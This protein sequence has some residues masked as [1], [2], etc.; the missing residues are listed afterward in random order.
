MTVQP[1]HVALYE[2]QSFL[3]AS[4]EHHFISHSLMTF[5]W[6]PYLDDFIRHIREV[7]C[8]LVIVDCVS[9]D[10]VLLQRLAPDFSMNTVL[11][12]APREDFELE[13]LLR[14]LGVDSVFPQGTSLTEIKRAVEKY[15]L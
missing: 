5:R 2:Q 10:S 1:R 11:A 12:V 9:V 6:L 4:L 7:R 13:C 15:L 14:E 8:D 3:T